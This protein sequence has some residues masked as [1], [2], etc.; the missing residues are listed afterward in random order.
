ME[1]LYKELKE[2]YSKLT[3]SY[4]LL[5]DSMKSLTKL[6]QESFN[7]DVEIAALRK[8][9]EALE[10]LATHY[11]VRIDDSSNGSTPLLLAFSIIDGARDYYYNK[12][13]K[14]KISNAK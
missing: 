11:D 13:N 8:Y 7:K 2:D 5:L 10:F 3:K 4:G 12:N 1:Q 6:N 9:K 14:E